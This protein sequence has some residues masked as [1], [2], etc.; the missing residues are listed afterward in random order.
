MVLSCSLVISRKKK[1]AFGN[2]INLLLTKFVG[3]RSLD[4]GRLCFLFDSF[5]SR[6][7]KGKY[8]LAKTL[9]HLDVKSLKTRHVMGTKMT[10]RITLSIDDTINKGDKHVITTKNP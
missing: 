10:N 8:G 5:F 4:I 1:N 6:V 2:I 9:S 7:F 3:S